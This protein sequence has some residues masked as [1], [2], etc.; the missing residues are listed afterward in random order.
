MGLTFK[1]LG[2][3]EQAIE[4]YEKAIELKPDYTEAYNNL[5]NVLR[6]TGKSDKAIEV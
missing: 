2:K 3:L 6:D 1:L 4:N 5:G